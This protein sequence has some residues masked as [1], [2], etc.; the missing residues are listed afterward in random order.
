M[1]SGSG[2]D[3]VAIDARADQPLTEIERIPLGDGV[4]NVSGFVPTADGFWIA[5]HGDT[6]T[7]VDF[8]GQVLATW[9]G[10]GVMSDLP[11]AFDLVGDVRLLPDGSI[12]V[13]SVQDER[14]VPFL[15]VIE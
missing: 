6:L 1:H 14:L 9:Q 13:L 7:P 2:Y 15:P 11:G 12:A 10:G 4:L 8:D 3:L 5:N